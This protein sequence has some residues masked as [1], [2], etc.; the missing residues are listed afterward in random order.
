MYEELLYWKKKDLLSQGHFWGWLKETKVKIKFYWVHGFK[1]TCDDVEENVQAMNIT[2]FRLRNSADD[3]LDK[4]KMEEMD[5]LR[6]D[7]TRWL[8]I[9]DVDHTLHSI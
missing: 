2:C 5:E 1:S 7:V 4:F 3:I 9:D 8:Q 6:Q